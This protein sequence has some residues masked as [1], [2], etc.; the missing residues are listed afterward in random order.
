MGKIHV[1]LS[2]EIVLLKDLSVFEQAVVMNMKKIIAA[3][4]EGDEKGNY[5]ELSKIVMRYPQSGLCYKVL[6]DI[7]KRAGIAQNVIPAP[8]HEEAV[9][10]FNKRFSTVPFAS[11]VTNFGFKPSELRKLLENGAIEGRKVGNV[12]FVVLSSLEDYQKRKSGD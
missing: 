6:Y 2:G 12:W 1:L 7:A 10:K 3:D 9:G 5:L 4:P 11:A 8:E